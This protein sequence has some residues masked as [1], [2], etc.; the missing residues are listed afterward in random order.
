MK[1]RY[2]Q[3][4]SK[5]ISRDRRNTRRRIRIRAR[6]IPVLGY[7]PVPNTQ[8]WVLG[9][10]HIYCVVL[11]LGD[12]FC[13]D[14]QYYTNQTAYVYHRKSFEILRGTVMQKCHFRSTHCQAVHSSVAI[15]IGHWY[16][17]LVLGIGIGYWVLVSLESS[18][19]GYWVLVLVLGIGIA[20]VQY[21]WVLDIGCIVWHRSNT[22]HR[23]KT[24]QSV[25]LNWWPMVHIY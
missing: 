6:T 12:I 23:T 21:Y 22:I 18:I 9:D 2:Y 4:C 1:T 17:A 5:H 15:G 11:L 7:R 3:Q 8:Y 14:T 16:W 20:R 24:L 10:I 19:I 13:C 25:Q